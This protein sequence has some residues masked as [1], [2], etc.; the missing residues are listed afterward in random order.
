MESAI[1]RTAKDGKFVHRKIETK[2]F[3]YYFR[4]PKN[5]MSEKPFAILYKFK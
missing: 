2:E 5:D 1:Y 4:S 3:I